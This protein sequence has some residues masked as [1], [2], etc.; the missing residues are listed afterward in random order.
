[1]SADPLQEPTAE[2]AALASALGRIPPPCH[3]LDP[4]KWYAP[5]PQPAIRICGDC[6]AKVECL[7]YARACGERFG[8]WGGAD[9]ERRQQTKRRREAS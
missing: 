1:M 9:L 2:L 5:D 6:H 3:A 7:I 4:E 8:V